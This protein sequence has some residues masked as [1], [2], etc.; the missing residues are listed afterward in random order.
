ME[1]GYLLA[2]GPPASIPR[3]RAR[4]DLFAKL[5]VHAVS[6]VRSTNSKR[7]FSAW[8]VAW[9]EKFS[10]NSVTALKRPG[11]DFFRKSP[12]DFQLAP[13]IDEEIQDDLFS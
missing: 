8:F 3:T 2:G 7:G 10:F 6:V 4:V 9:G 13:V 1:L 12:L 5:G 11:N